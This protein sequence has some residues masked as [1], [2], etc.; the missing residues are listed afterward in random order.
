MIRYRTLLLFNDPINSLKSFSILI[1]E[2]VIQVSKML[3]EIEALGRGH[4]LPFPEIG[5]L[6]LFDG[7]LH[8]S[9]GQPYSNKSYPQKQT[10]TALKF[11]G[12][13]PPNT[14]LRRAR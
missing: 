6:G 14:R 9:H 12:Q 8:D 4:G 11:G 2:L 7:A 13:P 1:F 5:L 10:R 3:N